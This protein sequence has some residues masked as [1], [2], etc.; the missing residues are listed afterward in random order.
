MR[1]LVTGSRDW[2]D[3]NKIWSELE[4]AYQDYFGSEKFVVV[5]GYCPTGADKQADAWARW[6]IEDE[7]R[8]VVV[9]PHPADWQGPRKRG[10]GFARNA[11]MVNLG[12][13]LCLA[14]IKDESNGATHCATLAQKAGIK[15]HIFRES[16]NKMADKNH[17]NPVKEELTLRDVRI[18]WRNFAGEARQYNDAG[19]RNFAIP[20][21][22]ELALEL[23]ALGWN[24]KDKESTDGSGDT[25]YHLS[26]N[27]KM[28]SRVPPRI[29]MITESRNSRTQLDEDTVKLL[30][31]AAF[32]MISLT[33]RAHN[34]GPMAGNKYGVTAYL[35]TGY[36]TIE[37]DAL[38]IEYAHIPLEG[39]DG[40][41]ELE[42]GAMD[43]EVLSETDWELDENDRKA[44]EAARN[45]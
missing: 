19:K 44:L 36:F 2:S 29:F 8:S 39:S 21:D 5:H 27:V 11:E 38:D 3:S 22:K 14:F 35:K 42:S 13:D 17:P 41:L 15:T 12:A 32:K 23:R 25:L 4:T 30:D 26:V 31:Y 9:E 33:L 10:A 18:M 6:A 16:S 37:E 24:V 40:L 7:Y 45:S 28:D 20:L 34:W 1:V 43:G